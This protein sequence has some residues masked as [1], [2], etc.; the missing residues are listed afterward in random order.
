MNQTHQQ[1]NAWQMNANQ[2]SKVTF[3][4]FAVRT[5]ACGLYVKSNAFPFDY[6][7]GPN[8]TTAKLHSADEL[9]GILN[10]HFG[11][12]Q[13]SG[14]HP[15]TA[16]SQCR[17]FVI[18]IDCKEWYPDRETRA[19]RNL[20]YALR[21]AEKL[22]KVGFFVI[23][24][25]SNGI[26]GYHIWVLLDSFV[27]QEW[28]YHFL[29]TLISD[30]EDCGFGKFVNANG[31]EQSD[32]PETFPKQ[33][34][35]KPAS[36]GNWVRQPGPHHRVQWWS[37]FVDD[38]GQLLS[39]EDSVQA[40]IDFRASDHRLIPEYV[41]PEIP[42]PAPQKITATSTTGVKGC[43]ES[44]QEHIEAMSWSEL[45]TGFGWQDCGGG[46]WRRPGKP[47]GGHSGQLNDIGLHVYSQA[48]ANLEAEKTY[49][50]WRFFVCSSGFS[51][52]G[53][54]QVEAARH[55]FGPEQA[56]AIDK[57]SRQAYAKQKEAS[58]PAV[59]LTGI[60]SSSELTKEVDEVWIVFNA[61]DEAE[62]QALG[63]VVV[64]AP[65]PKKEALTDWSTLSWRR[66]HIIDGG[67]PS[68]A[69]NVFSLVSHY[70][71]ESTVEIHPLL[72]SGEF[73]SKTLSQWFSENCNEGD[74]LQALRN[75]EFP[76]SEYITKAV[77]DIEIEQGLREKPRCSF[78][79][80]CAS[81]LSSWATQEADWLVQ[82][83]FT[84]DEPLLV[85]ARSKGCKTLQLTDLAV[86]VATGTK[87]FNV[88]NVP[89]RRKVL[90][91]TGEANYRRIAKHI[92]KACQRRDINFADLKGFLRVEAVEFPCLPSTDHQAAIRADVEQH[93]FEVVIIDP[94]YRGLA[95]VDSAR[96]SEM[97]SAIKSFQA[98]CH[99][100]MMILSH[101]VVK[102]AAREYGEPP[103]LEDMTGAG[104]AESCGQW[105]L[106]GRNEKYQWDWKHD[107]CVQFG[108]REGQGGGRRV[109]FNE[110]DWTFHVEGW[111]EYS[112]QAHAEH[113]QRREDVRRDAQER[114]RASARA[115]IMRAVRN[116]KTPQSKNQ[117]QQLSGAIQADFRSVFAE[118]VQEQTLIQRPY[119]DALNR[120]QMSGFL[121][122][123]YVNEFDSSGVLVDVR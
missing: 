118:M 115:A 106:V 65:A 117:I 96:L 77:E 47:S 98:A 14:L 3:G 39:I 78:A 41:A 87:W 80:I 12:V 40:W 45:L 59:N 21:L 79:G 31:E 4:R 72:T 49:G 24:E 46:M 120:V 57:E 103:T 18:D 60:L 83:V 43:R 27:P 93:G 19:A 13:T 82:E 64:R 84:I 56:D 119:K 97:G 17:W 113:E 25:A 26:G 121:L 114:K 75:I 61:V 107:L 30:A 16:D 88:F 53:I 71:K 52:E 73:N 58:Q 29:Q 15:Q 111:H 81:E 109:L 70:A 51:M 23:V 34:K 110:H 1:K 54:G 108:G 105:W 95:G 85:G 92:D 74:K 62:L 112:E 104:I 20:A 42:K 36:F 89:K 44:A 50:K 11:G 8:N 63:A 7:P 116:V 86:A 5:D 55:L 100:A 76:R 35:L 28:V 33:A 122:S 99:P 48:V 9:R 6:S 67:N 68:S 38:D 90:F 94:L 91:I 2:L 123:D 66:V 69:A 102:S 101:H 10:K 32:L 22:R 37:Q